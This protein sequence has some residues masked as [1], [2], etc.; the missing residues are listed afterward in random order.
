MKLKRVVG[1][2]CAAVLLIGILAGCSVTGTEPIPKEMDEQVLLTDGEV[3]VNLLLNGE[4]EAVVE[5]LREDI[6]NGGEKPILAEDIETLMQ[7]AAPETV[8][9]FV[10]I[11]DTSTMGKSDPEPQGIALFKCEY[12]EYEVVFGI[13]FDPE[14]N[15]IGI[16]IAHNNTTSV[17]QEE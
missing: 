6:R 4:Y 13:A 14:M 5:L 16:S 8:G 17:Q 10:E 3:V 1:A 11:S 15:L 2:V 7:L 12:T 9:T